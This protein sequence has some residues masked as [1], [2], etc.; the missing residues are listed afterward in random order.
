[1]FCCVARKLIVN[2]SFRQVPSQ[3]QRSFQLRQR[4][5]RTFFEAMVGC[6]EHERLS[7]HPIFTHSPPVVAARFGHLYKGVFKH[8]DTTDTAKYRPIPV[9]EPISR[10]YAS[11][12]ATAPC[13]IQSS[14]CGLPPRQATGQSLAPSILPSPFSMLLTST[15]T[16]A[17]LCTCV[18]WTSNQPMIR[19]SGSFFGA[20][21]S[22][23]GCTATCWA[24]CSLCMMALCC[25]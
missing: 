21:Y 14:S 11:I 8:G 24:Q 12:Y 15:D 23:W 20:C 18:L 10:L 9:G 16:L 6:A 25:P 2:M 7:V 1:M 19:S 5:D 17:D 4:R 13:H 22:A 3:R